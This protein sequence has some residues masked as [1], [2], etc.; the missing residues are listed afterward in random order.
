MF[1]VKQIVVLIS[2]FFFLSF[3]PNSIF[4]KNPLSKIIIYN[5]GKTIVGKSKSYE[6]IRIQK[7]SS[8]PNIVMEELMKADSIKAFL[9]LDIGKDHDCVC[10][11]VKLNYHALQ[12]TTSIRIPDKINSIYVDYVHPKTG[13]IHTEKVSLGKHVKGEYGVITI[14]ALGSLEGFNEE[15]SKFVSEAFKRKKEGRFDKEKWEEFISSVKQKLICKPKEEI[16]TIWL[17]N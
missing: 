3:F 6:I 2:T 9:Y 14:K 7:I 12:D 13:F 1:N 5:E 11:S 17:S 16:K 10:E 15:Q 4:G 8:D